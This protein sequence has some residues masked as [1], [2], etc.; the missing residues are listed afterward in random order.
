MISSE[1][2]ASFLV[3]VIG[4][5]TSVLVPVISEIKKVLQVANEVYKAFFRRFRFQW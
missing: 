4:I 1:L 3:T 5:N 2:E